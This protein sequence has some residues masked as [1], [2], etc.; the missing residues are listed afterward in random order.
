[1]YKWYHVPYIQGHKVWYLFSLGALFFLIWEISSQTKP[2]HLLSYEILHIYLLLLIYCWEQVWWVCVSWLLKISNKETLYSLLKCGLNVALNVFQNHFKSRSS[3]AFQS[4][5]Q[6]IS[7]F[8]LSISK[9]LK[10]LLKCVYDTVKCIIAGLVL[11]I[12]V[13]QP[14][15]FYTI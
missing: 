1:M 10:V 13:L 3:L 2:S 7:I 6:W 5:L 8:T 12:S 9:Y 11:L 14:E 4:S 15:P